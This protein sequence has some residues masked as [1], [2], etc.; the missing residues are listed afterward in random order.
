M[1]HLELIGATDVIPTRPFT[2]PSRIRH[3]MN[4]LCFMIDQLYLF[5]EQWSPHT[6]TLRPF[7]ISRP[8]PQHYLFRLIIAQ[9]EQLI[10][11]AALTCVGFLGH[12]RDEPDL[13]LAEEFDAT[14][15]AEI[16]D[17][18][19]LLCYSTMALLSGN[20]SNLVIFDNEESKTRW[21]HSQAHAQAVRKL[22]PYFYST[23]RLYNGL[24]PYDIAASNALR[25]TRIK[26]YDYEASPWWQ[27]VREMEQ[28]DKVTG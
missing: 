8:D 9:P 12:R 26:Y 22:A 14:L 4:T 24:L 10:D 1:T 3:D 11:A 16:P 21:S 13:A 7:T 25:I 20:Y 6:T 27:A 2:H 18:P 15:V 17:H 23:V 5:L 28:P 19:G